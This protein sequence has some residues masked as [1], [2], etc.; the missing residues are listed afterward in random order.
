MLYR[1]R[2]RYLAQYAVQWGQAQS[3]CY[4]MLRAYYLASLLYIYIYSTVESL[5]YL[6][7]VGKYKMCLLYV[8]KIGGRQGKHLGCDLRMHPVCN[9][10]GGSTNQAT[11]KLNWLG[12]FYRMVVSGNVSKYREIYV[13]SKIHYSLA[14]KLM[15]REKENERVR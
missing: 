6:I 9:M 5:M 3:K 7:Y 14:H 2:V 15:E 8:V 10:Q 4:F 11:L 1:Y 13:L 12:E